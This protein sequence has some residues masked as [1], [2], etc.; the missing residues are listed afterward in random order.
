MKITPLIKLLTM[1]EMAKLVAESDR[2]IACQA[3]AAMRTLLANPCC[4][5]LIV[6]G[7]ITLIVLIFRRLFGGNA[8]RS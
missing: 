3:A 5:T 7:V 4:I 1:P 2:F 6:G 8:P